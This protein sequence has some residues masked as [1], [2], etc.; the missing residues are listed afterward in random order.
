MTALNNKYDHSITAEDLFAYTGAVAAHSAYTARFQR[1]LVQPGLRIPITADAA[2]FAEAAELGREVVWLHCFGER[3]ADS[4]SGRPHAPPRL[5]PERAPTISK[6]GAIPT[7]PER[8]PNRLDYDPERQRLFVGEGFIDRV[9]PEIWAYEVSGKQVLM[10]WFSYRRRDRS[11]PLI[12]DRRPPS[13]LDKVQPDNWL[14]EYTTELMNLLHVLGRLVLLESRQA[15][16]LERICEGP[17][18]A[19][20]QLRALGAFDTPTSGRGGGT[21]SRQGD[22]LR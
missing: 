16:L 13:P 10:Q 18:L 14:P 17:L 11:R 2:L 7:E 6:E 12:G 21:D 8:M 15:D 5:P 1:D 3:F 9:P 4:A 22:L 20:D 19:A